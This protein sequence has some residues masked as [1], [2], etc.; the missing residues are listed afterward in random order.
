MNKLAQAAERVAVAM[1]TVGSLIF[2]TVVFLATFLCVIF[3]ASV[4]T[5]LLVLTTAVSLEAI[6][7]NIF[8]QMTV[9]SHTHDI[10]KI[11]KKMDEK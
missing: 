1:G 9:N 6:Y 3:G 10:K 2:H 7:M 11:H 5:T 8:L 4:N